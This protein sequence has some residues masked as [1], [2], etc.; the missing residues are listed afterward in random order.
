MDALF[1]TLKFLVTLVGVIAAIYNIVSSRTLLQ[2]Q[3]QKAKMDQA[4]A[5]GLQ[6]KNDIEALRQQV[7]MNKEAT[8]ESVEVIRKDIG[9]VK[10]ILVKWL[11][12]QARQ[13]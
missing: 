7:N 2:E 9:F 8:N 1:E 10:D 4:I 6:N 3:A 5:Q 12:D 13:S 11:L